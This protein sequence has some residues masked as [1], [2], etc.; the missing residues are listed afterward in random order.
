V[1][2]LWFYGLAVV[3]FTFGFLVCAILCGRK[4]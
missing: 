2:A 4:R 3:E 1:K